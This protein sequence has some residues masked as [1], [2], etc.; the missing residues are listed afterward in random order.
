MFMYA[1]VCTS[2][3]YA[4]L[5]QDEEVVDAFASAR[6][7]NFYGQVRGVIRFYQGVGGFNDSKLNVHMAFSLVLICNEG[8]CGRG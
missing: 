5:L 2:I 3:I 7:V 6:R 8:K 4:K 1:N